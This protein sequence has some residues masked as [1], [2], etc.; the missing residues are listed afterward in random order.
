[1]LKDEEIII[2]DLVKAMGGRVSF[3]TNEPTGNR[4]RMSF[5]K[6]IATNTLGAK[7]W[8]G[9]DTEG[10]PGIVHGGSIAAAMEEVM[11]LAAWVSGNAVLSVRLATNFKQMMPLNS[12]TYADTQLEVLDASK[13]RVVGHLFSEN[14]TPLA[15][16]EALFLIV[17][18]A[19]FGV[20]AEKIKVMFAALTD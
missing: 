9:P 10:G 20:D 2:V 1:M 4:I 19:K 16:A 6:R 18:A 11:R 7:I 17:P 13:I 3:V 8:F 14:G 5:Y 15:D 12:N